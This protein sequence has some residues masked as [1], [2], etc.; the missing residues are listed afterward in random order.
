MKVLESMLHVLD[1]LLTGLPGPD[2][3]SR[4]LYPDPNKPGLNPREREARLEVI[5]RTLTKDGHGGNR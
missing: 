3:P 1:R 2:D 4:P 5:R